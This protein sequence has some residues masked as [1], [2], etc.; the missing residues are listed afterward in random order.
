MGRVLFYHLTRS[1]VEDTLRSLLGKSLEA[2]LQVDVR[3]RDKARAEWLDQALWLGP[4]EQFLPHGLEGGPHDGRQ[5]VLLGTAPEARADSA[6]V[7]ALDGAEVSAE[8]ATRLERLCLLFDGAN[9]AS[10]TRAR[11]QWRA[12]S[13]AGA[14]LEYWS[15]E[16]GPWACKMKHPAA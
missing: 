4:E 16:D 10:L 8:E 7:M 13:A 11:E 1:T 6:C 9:E 15:Q 5:P 3:L 12:L 2:G 14:Q